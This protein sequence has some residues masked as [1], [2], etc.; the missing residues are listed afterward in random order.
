[1][2]FSVDGGD[3]GAAT[4]GMDS[5]DFDP[6]GDPELAM[7]LRISLEE[8]RARQQQVNHKYSDCSFITVA[9][10]HLLRRVATNPIKTRPKARHSL[11]TR[12]NRCFEKH[13]Q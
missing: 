10:C 5:M 11:W 1:M 4:G 8:Q 9:N 6:S 7:A 12:T 2:L 13:F 3:G